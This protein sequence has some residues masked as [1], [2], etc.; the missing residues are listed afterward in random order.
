MLGMTPLRLGLV[1]A[2]LFLSPLGGARSANAQSDAPSNKAVDK[3]AESAGSSAAAIKQYRDAVVLQNRAEYEL[4]AEEWNKFLKRFGDDPLAAKAQHYLGICQLQLKQ[5]PTA[6]ATFEQVI[7]KHPKFDLIDATHTNLGVAHFNQAQAGEGAEYDRAAASFAT[8]VERYPQSKQFG[9]AL[10]YLGESL[11]AREKRAEAAA[12]Y[13]KFVDSLPNHAMRAEA[14]YGLG[15]ALEE[16]GKATEAA[17]AYD[18][19]LQEFGKHEHAAEVTMRRGETLFSAGDF[20]AAEKWFARAAATA[21]FALADHAMLRQAAAVAEQKRLPEAAGLYASIIEKFPQSNQLSAATLAAGNCFYLAGAYADA[22]KW[23]SRAAARGD[24]SMVEASHWL[25]RAQLKLQQPKEALATVEKA[26]PSAA[27]H[28]LQVTLLLD[29]ADAIFEMPE[30]RSEAATLYATIAKEHLDH[31]QAPQ[32]L[33]LAAFTALNAGDHAAAERYAGAYLKRFANHS[34]VNDVRA[35]A[36]ETALQLAKPAEAEKLFDELLAGAGDHADAK[37]WQIR[38]ALAQVLQKKYDV[39]IKGLEPIIASL[40]TADSLAEAQHLMGSAELELQHYSAAVKALS[41]A[42]AAQPKWRQADETLLNLATAYRQNNQLAEAA[43]AARRL[44]ADHPQ[45]RLSARAH[46]RLADALSAQGEHEAAE[47]EYRAVLV[48]KGNPQ[49]APALFGLGWS[50]FHRENYAGSVATFNELLRDHAGHALASRALY[51]RALAHQQQKQYSEALADVN[52]YLKTNP[53]GADKSD[54][55]Y[56]EGL[57]AVALEKHGDAAALFAQLLL[58]NPGYPSADKVLYE[59]AWAHKSLQH[60]DEAQH[61]F[62]RLANEFAASPLAAEAQF[63]VGERHQSLKDYARASEA[64]FA[65]I[66]KSEKS[67]LQEKAAH[68]LAWCYYQ[69]DRLDDARKQ[70]EYQLAVYPEGPLVPDAHFMVGECRFKLKQFEPALESF[71]RAL[72]KP[73]ADREF[74]L[75]MGLH[76]GQAAAQLKLWPE[77]LKVLEQT[78]HDHPDSPYAAEFD[79]EQAWALQNLGRL[80]EAFVRYEQ[81]AQQVD[82]EIGVRAQFMMGEVRFQQKN[83]KEAIRNYLKVV[84]GFANDAPEGVQRWQAYA[85]YEAG[86]CY[87]NLNQSDK[88]KSLYQEVV[89]KFPKSDQAEL[90]R[91]R[92]KSLKG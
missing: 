17:A 65:A 12:A 26:L 52:A 70:F 68:K 36:A 57:C 22:V 32:A 4:A 53:S 48:E 85:A 92:L 54:A 31:S 7:A 37:Q 79:Y 55:L 16:L 41:A 42:L 83:Y 3:P 62:E 73:P 78:A 20:P 88:A 87:E 72:A 58:E 10:F 5:Y 66:K 29:R 91:T 51:A 18:K 67:E 63:R 59:L 56:L 35:V 24:D 76:A 9:Q 19:F 38:R 69:Q 82:R 43:A 84:G 44:I 39:A 81:V 6:I 64:F 90:A 60:E 11:Y 34:L 21:G 80:D 86:L 1:A 50:Q 77:G 47:A 75:L 40:K 15:V 71:R 89:E 30:R 61:A 46:Y 14:L 8:V 49:I 74:Q 45:S 27:G 2:A 33:Y 28:P 23:L 25:A 13:Q